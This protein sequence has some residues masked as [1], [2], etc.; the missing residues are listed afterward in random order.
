MIK[1]KVPIKKMEP[2]DCKNDQAIFC[3][4]MGHLFFYNV[5]NRLKKQLTL[6]K[7]NRFGNKQ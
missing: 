5:L 7:E 3:I 2:A 1:W 4:G 6:R